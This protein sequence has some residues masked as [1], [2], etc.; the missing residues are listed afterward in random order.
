MI[1]VTTS[2]Q[3]KA[4]AMFWILA[5][6]AAVSALMLFRI[7]N[8]SRDFTTNVATTSE[9]TDLKPLRLAIT[10]DEAAERLKQRTA[11]L[12]HWVWVDQTQSAE[13]V[14]V[15]NLVRQTMLFR[16]KD[17]VQVSISPA[18][19]AA[20]GVVLNAVSRSRVGQGDLGQNP[21]NIK[22]LFAAMR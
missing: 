16:F 18:I 10:T 6:V 5:I 14:V 19:D 9:S 15:V 7:D 8:W 13:G 11:D 2:H 1:F 4:K 22:E 17:D 20:P 12:S 3:R 21:R